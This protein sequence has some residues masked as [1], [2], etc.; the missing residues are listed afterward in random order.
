[1]LRTR[2][3][4]PE[5]ARDAP[6]K[7]IDDAGDWLT[8]REA[9]EATGVPSSTIRKWAR[10][11]NIPSL[12][13]ETSDGYLRVVSMRGMER[14]ASEIGRDIDL[15]DDSS[16]NEVDI[17]SDL[18]NRRDEPEKAPEGSMIVPLDAWNRMLNQLGNLHEA[19]QQLAEARERAAR[20]ET[21]ARFLKERLADLRH[22]LDK[23]SEAPPQEAVATDD[24][25]EP[26]TSSPT[27][28][29]KKAYD[30][31]RAKRRQSRD[32]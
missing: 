1:M 30:G 8:I 27:R 3:R 26:E 17:A 24:R 18:E 31:W 21:E 14:W 6:G 28:L 12:L 5:S 25:G 7:V 2:S 15:R 23:M 4:G 9:S 16:P 13:E 19:G 20:A 22:E 32:Q 29:I 10:H 11:D